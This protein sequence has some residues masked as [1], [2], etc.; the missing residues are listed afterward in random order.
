MVGFRAREKSS[1]R[2]QRSNSGATSLE[3][4]SP[5]FLEQ[6]QSSPPTAL[7]ILLVEDSEDDA[8]VLLRELQHSSVRKIICDRVETPTKFVA[9]LKD[10]YWDAIICD[11]CMPNFGALEA[12]ALLQEKGLD[13]P[14][15][16][17]SGLIEE[18]KGVEAMRAGAHDYIAK[19]NLSRLGPAL[20]REVHEAEAR[21]RHRE[22]EEALRRNEERYRIYVEESTEGIWCLELEEPVSTALPPDEQVEYLYRH[23]Y[24]AEC[25]GAIAEMHGY[26]CANELIG[27]QLSNLLPSS[28]PENIECL[29]TFVR[30]GYRLSDAARQ[31][32]NRQGTDKY[33]S[34]TFI[35]IIEDG[36]LARI[37]GTQRDVTDRKKAERGLDV[38]RAVTRA[39]TECSTLD[40][41]GSAILQVACEKVQ[42]EVAVLWEVD[43]QGGELRC[44]RTWNV[45][46]VEVAE[47]DDATRRLTLFRGA[48]LPGRAW[49]TG[50]PVW[51]PDLTE[52]I[53][54]A[55]RDPRASVAAKEGLRAA[56]ALPIWFER[57]ALGVV[58]FFSREV[59]HPNKPLLET[60][61]NIGAQIGQF[62]ERKRAEDKLRRSEE[63]F[64]LLI[65]GAKD[66]AIFMLD[67]EGRIT[68]WNTGA[69]SLLGYVE[70][71]VTGQCFSLLYS[72][73]EVRQGVPEQELRRAIDEGRAEAE[74][75]HVRKDGSRLWAGGV[76]TPL[77]DETGNL[78]GFAK[79]MRDFTERKQGEEALRRSEERFRL[80]VQNS[81]DI[82]VVLDVNGTVVYQSPSIERMLG[83]RSEDR[84]GENIFES[85]L[86]HPEDLKHVH[87]FLDRA[88]EE[89]G[90]KV[91]AEFR[92]RHA[93]GSWHC[94][95][96]IGRNLLEDPNVRG[97]VANYRDITERKE[98]EKQLRESEELHRTVV[99]Q[100]TENIYLVDIESKR[101]LVANA[102]LEQL[103]GYTTEELQR[104]TL[105]DI[106]ADTPKENV[107][108]D[109]LRACEEGRIFL[110]ERSY[111][112][113][114][115]TLMI[116][117]ASLSTVMYENRE[118]MCIIA[119]DLTERKQVEDRLR[120]SLDTL[121]A[122]Y[123]AGH[124]LGST[125]ESEE[126]VTRLLSIMQRTSNLIAAV[127]SSP[128]EHGQLRVWRAV[129]LDALQEK[130]R[131]KP[132]VQATLRS[133][134]M[135]A[136]P[137][138]QLLENLEEGTQSLTLLSLP[139]R[140]KN[141]TIGLLEVYSPE[142]TL[143]EDTVEILSGIAGQAAIAL[144]NARLYGELAERERLLEDL[145]G[146][147]IAAQEEERRHVAYEVHDGLAQV[148]AAAHQRLQSF[149]RRFPPTTDKARS[150]LNRILKLVQQTVG[151][152][153]RIISDLR[154]TTLDDFGLAAAL[155]QEVEALVGDGWQVEYEEEL[156]SERLPSK[157]EVGLFRVAQEAL[158]NARKHAQTRW[159]RL[160]LK[161]QEDVVDLEVRDWG[162]G[163][164]P[165]SLE[166]EVGPG[167]RVGLSGMRERVGLLGGELKVSS[168]PGEGTSVTV[169]V[170]L[171]TT[172]QDRQQE[173]HW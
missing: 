92:L 77:R 109:I 1:K 116:V 37:W 158:T 91:S 52:D 115:G 22:A 133:V 44:A 27:A 156:G 9:A 41:A 151:D 24:L 34:N 80:L 51:S 95:E 47:F 18:G 124:V 53:R 65:E 127:I 102:A 147:L 67:P 162:R 58:E 7:R 103:L 108:R 160:A 120:R 167:E 94:I 166:R 84:I 99:E 75:W 136:K 32:V 157:V 152:A 82:I 8:I 168:R 20:E 134:L 123:E 12:L 126:I 49:A 88:R 86:V 13:L 96:A 153:R 42:W 113:R 69:E 21:R 16:I 111:R 74:R 30:S 64:R 56:A 59:R 83:H 117:E 25:N 170:P 63:H 35:G 43:Q 112:H 100:T 142:K 143:E 50:K 130:A 131:Y 28:V 141:R 55:V 135:S 36:S 70:A 60:M 140:I 76:V 159:M 48:G 137:Q 173:E 165:R 2:A 169:H 114:D 155:R 132:K 125:L 89:P 10:A 101:I 62:V 46:S 79:V 98:V 104:L 106:V 122:L 81:S 57:E 121:I 26:T 164:N 11:Y 105:Y 110:G 161:R 6:P 146:K 19:S 38:Q 171:P 107:D 23:G 129:G 145:V 128:D 148:A 150:D 73:E 54:D 144:E 5:R 138:S 71:E 15:I 172:A 68:S 149:A 17:V 97:I 66:Y 139:L 87:D 39:L 72:P 154:P 29:R 163:F 14:F 33:F 45:P 4:S 61:E 119:H 85:P 31:E 3:A 118:V 40:E 78:R 93:D 90:T